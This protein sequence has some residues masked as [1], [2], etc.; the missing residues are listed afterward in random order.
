MKK[1]G[2]LTVIL[3]AVVA[4][5]LCGCITVVDNCTDV[6]ALLQ[7]HYDAYTWTIVVQ[8][9][10][11]T[12]TSTFAIADNNDNTTVAYTV[13]SFAPIS[14]NQ[15]ATDYITTK[16]GTA[17]VADGN[18]IEQ[19][20]DALDNVDL[21]ALA[22]FMVKFNAAYLTNIKWDKDAASVQAAVSNP[23]G[24]MGTTGKQYTDMTVAI[25]YPDNNLQDMTIGYQAN[26]CTVT[27]TCAVGATA[28]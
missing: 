9:G 6:N 4:V 3:C 12:L 7:K 28:A 22:G 15:A 24:F 19:T 18:V 11:D 20:G 26:G 2:F 5:A 16:T 17:T 27:I 21:A 1:F 10:E 14:L 23:N 13:Q 8:S 25:H